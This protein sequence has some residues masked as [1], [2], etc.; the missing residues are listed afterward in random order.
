MPRATALWGTRP[1][2]DEGEY[3]PAGSN[4]STEASQPYLGRGAVRVALANVSCT[5]HGAGRTCAM[6]RR[7]FRR[8]GLSQIHHWHVRWP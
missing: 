7:S 8:R 4:W 1:G 2:V 3:D 5:G 6:S